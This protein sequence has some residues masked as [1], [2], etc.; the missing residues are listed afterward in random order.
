MSRQQEIIQLMVEINQ[1]E[2]KRN[3]ESTKPG[4]GSLRKSR[5]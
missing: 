1:I 2:T 5:R 4:T 3:K